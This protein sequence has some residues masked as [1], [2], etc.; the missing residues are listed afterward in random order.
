M[1]KTSDNTSMKV[2]KIKSYGFGYDIDNVKDV[3]DYVIDNYATEDYNI[4]IAQGDDVMN[5]LT[6][7]RAAD[8]QLDELI[9]CCD[10][11]GY[12]EE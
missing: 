5:H 6:I 2:K 11:E 4:H 9:A 10:G 12:F 8:D 1:T 3:Q 7:N